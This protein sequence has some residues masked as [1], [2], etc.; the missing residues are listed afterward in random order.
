M[1]W[2]RLD[3]SELAQS[4]AHLRDVGFALDATSRRV[5]TAC[6]SPGLGH[7]GAAL[8]VEGRG[9]ADQ[10][11]RITEEYLR[12]AVDV[13]VRALAVAWENALVTSVA[14]VGTV[15]T[16]ATTVGTV[17]AVGTG[18]GSSFGTGFSALHTTS[19]TGGVTMASYSHTDNLTPVTMAPVGGV[20]LFGRPA[21]GVTASTGSVADQQNA[22]LVTREQL[23]QL[24]AL[25]GLGNPFTGYSQS[26]LQ[27]YERK[28]GSSFMGVSA[29]E[30]FGS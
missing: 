3:P 11:V 20:G 23:G 16:V 22:A 9:L 28:F 12:Q 18:S 30:R 1:T 2:I 4:G 21:G 14:S 13:L 19:P 25:Q 15:G 8:A 5:D 10:I 24:G 6:C 27:T 17:G 29:K 26:G 7:C